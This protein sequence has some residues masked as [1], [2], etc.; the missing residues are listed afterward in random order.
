MEGEA[1]EGL[2]SEYNDF[3]IESVLKSVTHGAFLALLH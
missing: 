3:N 1:V 2:E